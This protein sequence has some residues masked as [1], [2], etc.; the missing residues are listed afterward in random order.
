MRVQE[1]AGVQRPTANIGVTTVS[2]V[3]TGLHEA[4]AVR[5]STD[6]RNVVDGRCAVTGYDGVR[7]TQSLGNCAL[8]MLTPLTGECITGRLRQLGVIPAIDTR[9]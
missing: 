8:C 5:K 3:G 1:V 7:Q 9:R 4:Y 2:A 6:D